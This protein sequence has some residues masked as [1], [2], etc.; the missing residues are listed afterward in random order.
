MTKA[1]NLLL[2]ILAGLFLIVPIA[3]LSDEQPPRLA[4]TWTMMPKADQSSEFYE[5]LAK[6]VQ[7]RSEAGD[8]RIWKT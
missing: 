7:F 2:S 3:G 6:H 4:E 5:G 8:P 1:S